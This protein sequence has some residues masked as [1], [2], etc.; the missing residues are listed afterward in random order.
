MANNCTN[1]E[2][3]TFFEAGDAP[4][5]QNF[6]DLIDSNL[7]LNSNNC[8]KGAINGNLRLSATDTESS[9][10]IGMYNASLAETDGTYKGDHLS[11]HG[12]YRNN[13]LPNDAGYDS[14]CTGA[15]IEIFGNLPPEACRTVSCNGIRYDA[16]THYFRDVDADP[17]NLL[18]LETRQT[19][20]G[21]A[22]AKFISMG[23]ESASVP[24][25][26]AIGVCQGNNMECMTHELT[27]KGSLS[28]SGCVSF[29]DTLQ[30]SNII[31]GN[32][33]N[34]IKGL[35]A[36]NSTGNNIFL[37]DLPTTDPGIQG[38]LYRDGSG[39]LKVSI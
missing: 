9:K 28:S 16:K 31:K 12:P 10:I 17:N 15:N 2:L 4:T 13:C 24:T 29:G 20:S 39:N 26:V 21:T 3:K 32:E 5:Q 6:A 33:L 7:N 19:D 25:R 27:V 18:I 36:T 34:L 22:S 23:N 37:S 11:L 1:N 8:F 30:V 35:S 38:A 14:S